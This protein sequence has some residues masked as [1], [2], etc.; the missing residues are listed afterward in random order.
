MELLGLRFQK[1]AD[2]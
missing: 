1:T 2:V